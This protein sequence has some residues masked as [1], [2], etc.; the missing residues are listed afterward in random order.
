MKYKDYITS[1]MWYEKR[2]WFLEL[3]PSCKVCEIRRE[4]VVIKKGKEATQVHHLHYKTVTNEGKKDLLPVCKWCHT[5][6]HD[7][8]LEGSRQ[9]WNFEITNEGDGVWW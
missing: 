4:G 3:Y 5:K 6:I 1:P 8:S 2:N 7:N 9:R